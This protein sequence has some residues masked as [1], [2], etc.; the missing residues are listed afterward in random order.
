MC[1]PAE[2]QSSKSAGR[3]IVWDADRGDQ[4]TQNFALGNN[5]KLLQKVVTMLGV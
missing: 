3:T 2:D 4:K 5:T 1:I